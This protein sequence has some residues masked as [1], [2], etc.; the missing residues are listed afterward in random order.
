[1]FSD[2]KAQIENELE[3]LKLENKKLIEA[4]RTHRNQRGNDRCWVDDIELYKVL[5]EGPPS[6]EELALPCK[7]K[8][9]AS[10]EKYYNFRQAP[11]SEPWVSAQ[12]LEEKI[13]ELEKEL[14]AKNTHYFYY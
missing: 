3:I 6:E 13:R 5:P 10:C 7:Q 11:G 12:E 9:L 4:I 14:E 8:F 2:F 1:M